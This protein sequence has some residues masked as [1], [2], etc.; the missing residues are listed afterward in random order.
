MINKTI[1]TKIERPAPEI[2]ELLRGVPVANIADEMGRIG[3]P[4]YELHAFNK[5]PLLG[6]AFTVKTI[7][8]DNL[9]FHKA[10]QMGQ[11]G[12]V[13]VVDCEGSITHSVCGEMMFHMARGRGIEGFVVDGLIRDCDSLAD[14]DFSV[15]DSSSIPR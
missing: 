6:V 4:S 7:A 2:L 5:R 3:C 11:P 12:D 10:I 14:M 13:I 1:H 8:N 15:A 9:L